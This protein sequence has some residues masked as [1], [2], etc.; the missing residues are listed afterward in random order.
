M[1]TTTISQTFPNFGL[2]GIQLALAA[3]LALF[4]GYI[5]QAGVPGSV[6]AAAYAIV[7]AMQMAEQAVLGWTR[8]CVAAA[9]VNVL[10]LAAVAMEPGALNMG[11]AW[12]SLAG[13]ALMQNG[14]HPAR[15]AALAKSA[16]ASLFAAPWGLLME[17][18]R[19]NP[20]AAALSGFLLPV[21]AVAV[22]GALLMTA[23][24]IIERALSGISFERILDTWMPA[25]TIAAFIATY[26]LMR[27]TADLGM[28][29]ARAPFGASIFAPG[30]VA[31]TLIL[32]NAMFLIENG[33]DLVYV[34]SGTALPAAMTHA[35]YVHRGAYALVATAVLAGALAMLALQPGSASE[36]SRAVRWLVYL[37]TLQNVLLVASSA[38]RTLAYVDAYGMTLWRLSGLIWM[39]LVAAGL[40]FIAARVFGKRSG[41]WL[42]NANLGAAFLVLLAC[43][44]I[45]LRA[46][47]AEWN[48][49]RALA[50]VGPM[51]HGPDIDLNYL[52]GLGPSAIAPLQ[53]LGAPASYALAP[54]CT[55]LN[56]AQ[57]DWTRWTARNWAYDSC[58]PP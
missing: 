27:M 53:R 12:A 35:E 11:V 57:A 55:R 24:P 13:F 1:T 28:G 40:M 41:T 2:R 49:S 42:M 51:Q 30:P 31:M 10:A 8:A 33:L 20:R 4:V 44:M 38:Q 43:G 39:G 14:A 36:A 52:A 48:V 32:L 18:R 17:M 56:N 45:D 34:W 29:E 46:I 21:L 19:V 26:A 7:F 22:F 15:F 50:Q 6:V 5:S 23:N 58:G 47:V 3:V 9:A 54:L 37:W 16:L 25:V